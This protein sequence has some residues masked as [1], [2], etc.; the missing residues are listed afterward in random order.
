MRSKRIGM[1]II[2]FLISFYLFSF[3]Y[4]QAAGLSWQEIWGQAQNFIHTGM[5]TP[6]I[7][8]GA[9]AD[10]LIPIAQI[11]VGIATVVLVIVTLIM[12]IKYMVSKPEDRAKL[13]QQLV[14]LVVATAVVFGAQF[15]WALMYNFMK[16]LF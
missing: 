2:C 7:S 4:V 12:G 8:P 3:S 15:I 5:Q 6:T 10:N 13:K 16:D 9:L 14:G 11:L 1:I